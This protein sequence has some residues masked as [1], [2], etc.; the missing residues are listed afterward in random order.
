MTAQQNPYLVSVKVS[1]GL[2]VLY[3]VVG[4]LFILLALIALLAGAI[5]FYLI[6]GP[7][8][9]AMGI[10]TLMR[11]YCIYDTATGALGLFSP[12]GF[13]VRSFGA[14]KGERIYYNPATAKVMRALPN[15]AQK[16]VSMFGVNK[17]QLARLIATLPQHQ[18]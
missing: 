13:Q 8:F 15:G 1:T 7:L 12:L 11:P 6:L 17:D 3:M 2:S 5:S 16:K 4:G 14:P 18:A 10:L 9:L